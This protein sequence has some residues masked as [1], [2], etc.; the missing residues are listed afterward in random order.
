MSCV[1]S[2]FGYLHE[3]E[4]VSATVML[5]VLSMP[6]QTTNV[7]QAVIRVVVAASMQSTMSTAGCSFC[8]SAMAYCMMET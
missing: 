5:T 7:P 4:L 3:T 8:Y 6:R 2:F 1:M